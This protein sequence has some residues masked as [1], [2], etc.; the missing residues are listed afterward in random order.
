MQTVD[1][2]D[3]IT[4]LP[5]RMSVPPQVPTM[6]IPSTGVIT[7]RPP[8]APVIPQPMP[9]APIAAALPNPIAAQPT[10]QSLMAEILSGQRPI[11][12]ARE[13][14]TSSTRRIP[15]PGYQAAIG[16]LGGAFAQQGA[17]AEALGAVEIK[18]AQESNQ[19]MGE[20]AKMVETQAAE[21]LAKQ[22]ELYDAAEMRTIA[23]DKEIERLSNTDYEGFWQK[24][25]TGNQ[26]LGALS[27]ALGSIG[28]ALTGGENQALSI[29]NK[30]MDMDYQEFTDKI[31]KQL[32]AIDR[33][34]LSDEAKMQLATQRI[35]ALDGYQQA[36][37]NVVDRKLAAVETKFAN[38]E[39]KAKV[40]NLR[41]GLQ[42]QM[43]QIMM[44]NEKD[45]AQTV[46]SQTVDRPID[47]KG[48]G[49]DA[50]KIKDQQYKDETD[51]R[52]E[53]DSDKPIAALRD[54]YIRLKQLE[55][56]SNK[57]VADKLALTIINKALQPESASM[58]SE[59]DNIKAAQSYGDK[60]AGYFE[61]VF[62]GNSLRPEMRKDLVNE[63]R[64]IIDASRTA[65]EPRIDQYSSIVASK[66]F[67]PYHVLGPLAMPVA[68]PGYVIM[69]SPEGAGPVTYRNVPADRV[70]DLEK[71]GA[72]RVK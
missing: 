25:G 62:K 34:R 2:I 36:Q 1:D 55:N 31:Q 63:L 49:E 40:Q 21:K 48:L 17:A 64:R 65:L 30:A 6:T 54:G 41:A 43:A 59:E 15:S 56:M 38:E 67:D 52:K 51:L 5:R 72:K 4:G 26:I 45:M 37:L 14:T 3:P 60:V 24:R 8:I 19:L 39:V 29:I 57:P 70:A 9:V 35:G 7:A 50:K 44:Q 10:Q 27:I 13:T 47:L 53:F 18:K 33:S 42:S 68:Q 11:P 22:T 32:A 61:Y 66:G 28:S 23:R 69:R 16:Q 12:T 20:A 71:I 58:L 46:T